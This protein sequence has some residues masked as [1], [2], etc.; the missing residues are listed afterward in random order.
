[1]GIGKDAE[2]KMQERIKRLGET[3][4]QQSEKTPVESEGRVEKTTQTRENELK[5]KS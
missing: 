2:E 3:S 4:F 1:M 5:K